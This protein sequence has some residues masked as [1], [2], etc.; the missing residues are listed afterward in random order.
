MKFLDRLGWPVEL[1]RGRYVL[2]AL[3]LMIHTRKI[4]RRWTPPKFA[5]DP[6][7]QCAPQK[8]SA[9]GT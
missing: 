4:V 8:G 5:A 6:S 7:I 2:N 3:R 9:G 1:A